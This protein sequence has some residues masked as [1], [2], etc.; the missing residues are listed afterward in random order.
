MQHTSHRSSL[1][2]MA[3]CPV[4]TMKGTKHSPTPWLTVP[5]RDGDHDDARRSSLAL[6]SVASAAAALLL[7]G[8]QI[9][10]HQ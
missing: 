10:H 7:Y 2:P 5:Y 4:L 1:L 9:S 3:A 8:K 6:A